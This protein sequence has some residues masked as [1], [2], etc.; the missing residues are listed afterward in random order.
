MWTTH[1]HSAIIGE[2]LLFSM[3]MVPL[4]HRWSTR[5]L[6]HQPG[7]PDWSKVCLSFQSKCLFHP[8]PSWQEEENTWTPRGFGRSS[9]ISWYNKV[10]RGTLL[11][12]RVI[13]HAIKA[14]ACIL[15]TD[16]QLG[17]KEEKVRL[18]LQPR[19]VLPR[20]PESIP[21]LSRRPVS[22]SACSW[23]K[24]ELVWSYIQQG[25]ISYT[26]KVMSSTFCFVAFRIAY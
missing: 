8:S 4:M 26:Q 18:L 21:A 14:R 1:S 10:R 24:A 6:L 5:S 3:V 25:F 17:Y 7:N 20:H 19:Q 22:Y 9:F 11:L 23:N 13:W 16:S 15:G 12:H 2:H